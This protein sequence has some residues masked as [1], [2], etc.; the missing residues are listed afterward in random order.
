LLAAVYLILIQ[1]SI[2]RN[3]LLYLKYIH[4]KDKVQQ[5]NLY[6]QS[7]SQFDLYGNVLLNY[8]SNHKNL[9]KSLDDLYYRN[10]IVMK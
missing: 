8:H 9:S 2:F 5:Q 10:A 3:R 7:Q 1:L 4:D 6:V